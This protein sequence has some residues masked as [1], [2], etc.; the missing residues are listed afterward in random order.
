MTNKY[1][2]S[3]EIIGKNKYN[4]KVEIIFQYSVLKIKI[5]ARLKLPDIS[6]NNS[7]LWEISDQL[8]Y[9]GGKS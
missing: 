7:S 8:L 2:C 9:R 4:F 5:K 6:S 3:D 1:T